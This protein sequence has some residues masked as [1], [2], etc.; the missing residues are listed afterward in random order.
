[1]PR[2][3]ISRTGSTPHLWGLA[4]VVAAIVGAGGVAYACGGGGGGGGCNG[5]FQG[6]GGNNCQTDLA[7]EWHTPTSTTPSAATVSCTLWL[8]TSVLSIG[9]AGLAPGQSCGFSAVLENVGKEAVAL[10]ETVAI[11]EPP[12]CAYFHYSDNLPSSP[13]ETLDAGHSVTVHGTI[14]LSASAGSACEG[15]SAL[16]LVTIAGSESSCKSDP[17]SELS[18][19]GEAPLWSC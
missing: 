5:Q 15:K 17:Y 2:L 8:T 7:I 19:S 3:R 4:I 16:I 14:S 10:T 1:M 12:V 6:D 9:V 13:P 11:G 18:R